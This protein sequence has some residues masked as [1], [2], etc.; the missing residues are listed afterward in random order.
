MMKAPNIKIFADGAVLDDVPKLLANG[1]LKGFTTNPTL[2][3]KAGVTDYE[4]FAKKF[5]AAVGQY[6]VSLEVFADDLPNM[7]R[8]ARI[9][10]GWGDNVFVK[11]P[12]TNTKGETTRE[13]VAQLSKEGV[14]LN[15]TA[16]FTRPQVDGLMPCLAPGVP[17]IVSVFAGR[18]A[19]AGVDPAPMIRYAVEA[20]V[21]R[22]E[23][24]VLWASCREIFNVVQAAEAG[25]H[26]ITVPNDMLKKLESCG[27]DLAEISLDTVKMFFNDAK[28]SGFQL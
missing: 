14:K 2:M 8:Q 4:G 20:A 13:A 21:G 15:V 28:A 26:I 11:I 10:A 9:L 5:L 12:I 23:V 1:R 3:A 18:I 27:K 17:A 16:V 22:P 7:V 25:C 24:E 19:D 6:P